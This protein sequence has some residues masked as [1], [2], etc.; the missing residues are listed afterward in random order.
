[1]DLPL[2]TRILQFAIERGQ[3]F[4]LSDVFDGLIPEYDGERLFNRK[5]VEEYTEALLGVGFLKATNM[6]FD[7]NG[8]LLIEYQATDYGKSREKYIH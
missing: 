8:Q 4:T 3:P 5:T 6:S 1:M 7:E 2:K